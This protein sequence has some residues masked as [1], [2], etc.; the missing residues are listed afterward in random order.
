MPALPHDHV[1]GGQSAQVW[2]LAQ[3]PPAPSLCQR[4]HLSLR[5]GFGGHGPLTLPGGL[6]RTGSRELGALVGPAL[7]T[8]AAIVHSQVVCAVGR[9]VHAVAFLQQLEELLHWD[10]RVRRAPQ[11]EDLPEQD[12]K[13]P[14]VGWGAPHH[15]P[16]LKLM[17]PPAPE[18]TPWTPE[19]MDQVQ[20]PVGVPAPPGAPM[21]PPLE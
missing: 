5:N 3:S 1:P 9:L 10:A 8:G 13:G 15:E 4:P 2:L 17:G 18:Q 6:R 16:A 20:A 11:C 14:A 7:W 19:G 12:P 21:T